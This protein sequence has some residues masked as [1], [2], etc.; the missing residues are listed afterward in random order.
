MA[1]IQ[2]WTKVL[3][4]PTDNLG[5]GIKVIQKSGLRIALVVG[6]DNKLQGTLTDGD[7]RRALISGMTM[8]VDISEV[9]N[10]N[11]ITAKK[12][13]SKEHILLIL[14]FY[15]KFHPQQLL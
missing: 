2:N 13:D 1:I 8:S 14:Q 9:M 4:K 11:P 15:Q 10:K 7:V 5:K 6:K 12:T 3:I